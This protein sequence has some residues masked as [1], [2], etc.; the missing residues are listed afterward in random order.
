MWDGWERN[1]YVYKNKLPY[2]YMCYFICLVTEV[3]V[4]VAK[5]DIHRQFQ[6][7]DYNPVQWKEPALEGSFLPN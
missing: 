1:I 5:L 4:I 6:R 2:T 7:Y 3:M